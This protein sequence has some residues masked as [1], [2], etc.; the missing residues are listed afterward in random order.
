MAT[1]NFINGGEVQID[2]AN[3]NV[4]LSQIFQ[5][6]APDFGGNV[7]NQAGLGDKSAVLRYIAPFITDPEAKTALAQSP[8]QFR[9]HYNRYDW[10][11]NLTPASA[12]AI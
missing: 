8:E 3:R 1:H 7:L 10:G 5:W 6:Y 12:S 2:M 9:I 4:Y 11:L